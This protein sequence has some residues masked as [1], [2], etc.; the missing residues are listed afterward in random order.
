MEVLEAPA[1]RRLG[2][3]LTAP[4]S[5]DALTLGDLLIRATS[6]WPDRD[7]IIFPDRR[8]T[9][10]QLHE[11]ALKIARGLRAL[12]LGRGQH[13]GLFMGNGPDY[14]EAFFGIALLGGTLRLR[15]VTRLWRRC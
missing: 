9:Y 11:G 6:L 7:A 14:V 1:S 4:A 10:A 3:V 8:L 12:G 15:Q 2:A 5:P 13:I